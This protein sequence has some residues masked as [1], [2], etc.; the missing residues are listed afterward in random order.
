MGG[1]D[2]EVLQPV[3][4]HYLLDGYS[5]SSTAIRH[6][7]DYQTS[8]QAFPTHFS[9]ISHAFPKCLPVA[10]HAFPPTETLHVLTTCVYCLA[11]CLA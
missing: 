3:A 6:S 10:F 5:L 7:H 8:C 4:M 9:R 1:R 2:G 11:T